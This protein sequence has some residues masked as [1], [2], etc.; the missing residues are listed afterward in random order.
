M[1]PE[2]RLPQSRN[3]LEQKRSKKTSL[4]Y[5]SEKQNKLINNK[6]TA[7]KRFHFKSLHDNG[8][9]YSTGNEFNTFTVS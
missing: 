7:K 2:K 1:T 4:W 6:T 9:V 5:I 8:H 3:F